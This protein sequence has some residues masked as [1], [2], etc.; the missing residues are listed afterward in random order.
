MAIYHLTTRAQWERARVVGFYTAGSLDEA[1][2]IHCSTAEQLLPVANAFYRD[3]DDPIV[4]E[5][6]PERLTAPLVW[7]APDPP[8]VLDG[9]RFPHVYGPIDLEAVTGL[10][11]LERD[12][13]G[14][15]TAFF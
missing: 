11:T 10:K 3:A 15:Y 7:E 8:G 2:F 12:A 4:L 9:D 6:D 1:G 13:E 5:I 14:R